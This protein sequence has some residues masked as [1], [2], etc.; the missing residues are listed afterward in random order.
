MKSLKEILDERKRLLE[1]KKI[2]GRLEQ[3]T[4]PLAVRLKETFSLSIELN[5]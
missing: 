5:K 4:S 1:E 3:A 2:G